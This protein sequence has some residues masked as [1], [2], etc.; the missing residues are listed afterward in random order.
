MLSPGK[1]SI[2]AY[3]GKWFWSNN[4]S[5]LYYLSRPF[6]GLVARACANNFFFPVACQMLQWIVLARETQRVSYR[7]LQTFPR[8][9]DKG[10]GGRP[11]ILLTAREIFVS[12]GS[13]PKAICET[14]FMAD[15]PNF[16]RHGLCDSVPDRRTSI[17]LGI[18]EPLLHLRESFHPSIIV[19]VPR[20]TTLI[21]CS[22]YRHVSQLSEAYVSAGRTVGLDRQTRIWTFFDVS[23]ASSKLLKNK[24]HEGARFLLDGSGTKSPVIFPSQSKWSCK[25]EPSEMFVPSSVNGSSETR[26][27]HIKIAFARFSY[28]RTFHGTVEIGHHS[29]RLNYTASPRSSLSFLPIL[30]L[31]SMMLLKVALKEAWRL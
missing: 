29:V 18:T 13:R 24:V 8:T 26:R 9:S 16:L 21:A 31:A 19:S 25:L 15:P 6:D 7:P 23:M 11:G 2:S 4:T 5:K 12:Y 17:K 14:H 20:Y 3:R 30:N 22:L 27:F 1:S 28:S 10:A